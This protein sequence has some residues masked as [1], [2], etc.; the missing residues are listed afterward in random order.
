MRLVALFHRQGETFPRLAGCYPEPALSAVLAPV[1]GLSRGGSRAQIDT[2]KPL[3]GRS[4][5]VDG[6]GERLLGGHER[7]RPL[8]EPRPA[9]DP[10]GDLHRLRVREL[11]RRLQLAGDLVL[12][13]PGQEQVGG[14][15]GLARPSVRRPSRAAGRWVPSPFSAPWRAWVPLRSSVVFAF[16]VF[17]VS[18]LFFMLFSVLLLWFAPNERSARVRE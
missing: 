5:G 16:G 9:D 18:V 17:L 4:R 12:A 8:E 2:K 1:C 6:D 11:E 7:Q 15:P 10:A 13:L 14:E 3:E